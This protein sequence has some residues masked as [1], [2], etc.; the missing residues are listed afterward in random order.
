MEETRGCCSLQSQWPRREMNSLGHRGAP[1]PARSEREKLGLHSPPE[2]VF[3]LIL[4][5]AQQPPL[6]LG[7]QR[8]L[9]AGAFFH[10]T[11]QLPEA[12]VSHTLAAPPPHRLWQLQG[13]TAAQSSP[14]PLTGLFLV[15]SPRCLGRASPGPSAHLHFLTTSAEAGYYPSAT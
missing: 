15:A 13:H 3:S 4:I 14:Q 6:A 5:R 1:R 7:N 10:G 12:T 11:N 9:C 2:R 8:L